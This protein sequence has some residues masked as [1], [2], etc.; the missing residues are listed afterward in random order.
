VA[1]CKCYLTCSIQKPPR[2][3]ILGLFLLDKHTFWQLIPAFFINIIFV[4][5]KASLERKN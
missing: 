3:L 2:K 4:L 1:W 5:P